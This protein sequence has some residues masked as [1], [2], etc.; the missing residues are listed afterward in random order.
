MVHECERLK[1]KKNFHKYQF[2][3]TFGQ[4]GSNTL[5]MLYVQQIINISGRGDRNLKKPKYVRTRSDPFYLKK[6]KNSKKEKEDV[7]ALPAV[8][9]HGLNVSLIA[10]GTLGSGGSNGSGAQGTQSLL[11]PLYSCEDSLPE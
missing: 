7:F 5:L 11:Q 10:A 1:K 3:E 2:G 6:S 4:I 8:C 9:P